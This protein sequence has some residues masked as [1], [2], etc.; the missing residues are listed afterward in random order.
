MIFDHLIRIQCFFAD[1]A[2]M[3][4]CGRGGRGERKGKERIKKREERIGKEK[5]K[6]KTEKEGRKRGNKEEGKSE[7]RVWEVRRKERVD[8][9]EKSQKA[10]WLN[11]ANSHYGA[12]VIYL[13]LMHSSMHLKQYLCPHGVTQASSM[14]DMHIGQWKCS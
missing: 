10:W 14:R 9:K 3:S 7:R 6:K 11:F 13:L 8:E 2:F 12:T 5:K 1:R 4:A